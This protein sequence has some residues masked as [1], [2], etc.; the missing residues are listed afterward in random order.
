MTTGGYVVQT[1]D[2]TAFSVLD[3]CPVL[4]GQTP[5]DA[6]ANTTA[7]AKAVDELGYTRYWM[8]EHHNM[9]GIA[10]SATS[11]LIGHV[12]G[13]TKRIRVGSGGIM[14]PNHAPLVIAEQFG[15]LESLYPNRI[16][17][18]LGRAP[19]SDGLTARALR[20]LTHNT[21]DDF[22]QLLEE[23]MRYFWGE[24]RVK[25]VPGEG[26]EVPIW[27]LG[28]SGFSAQLA[29][30]LG[31]PFAFAAQ[32]APAFLDQALSIYRDHFTPSAYLD[33]PYA[34]V[35]TNIIVAETDEEAQFL[36]TSQQQHVLSIFRNT[37]GKLQPPVESMDALWQGHEIASVESFLGASIVGSPTTVKA[38]L[39]RFIARTQ[40]NELIVN[41]AVY[42]QVARRESYR[43]LREIWG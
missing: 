35:G 28:S 2:N 34:M 26:L 39:E 16:D 19:G 41:C 25:A 31:L 7:L 1:L 40:A 15:T 3:L 21:G 33:A 11:I 9:Q 12:A 17:L 29:G 30:Q 43:L 42:D 6:F 18:G 10:S 22:P 32:F 5:A 20:R 36:F 37:R 38:G 24:N 27:L 13:V 8:A 23:L 14:L 4:E